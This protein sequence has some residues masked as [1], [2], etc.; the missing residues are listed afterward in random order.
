[1]PDTYHLTVT[2]GPQE[3]RKLCL[4]AIIVEGAPMRLIDAEIDTSE[5]VLTSDGTNAFRC[6]CLAESMIRHAL[7]LPLESDE[8][9]HL[10][11]QIERLQQQ[12]AELASAEPETLSDKN[13]TP[14][15]SG[16]AST[17]GAVGRIAMADCSH[18]N[19]QL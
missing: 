14:P 8:I 13:Q 15:P 5:G 1:M 2:T 7:G 19:P 9:V 18:T 4:S 11:A 16:S 12:I 6:L 17:Q 3:R 10:K